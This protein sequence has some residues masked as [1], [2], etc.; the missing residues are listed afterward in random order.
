MICQAKLAH[1]HIGTVHVVIKSQYIVS[2]GHVKIPEAKVCCQIVN[3]ISMPSECEVLQSIF[4]AYGLALIIDCGS[5]Y[6][7][8]NAILEGIAFR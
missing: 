8:A 2:I 1:K 5:Q 3:F 4:C 6:G 7:R